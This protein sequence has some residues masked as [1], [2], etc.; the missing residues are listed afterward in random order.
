[1][2]LPVEKLV[3]LQLMLD[4]TYDGDSVGITLLGEVLTEL[5]SLAKGGPEE[6]ILREL[7]QLSNAPDFLERVRRFVSKKL[8]GKADIV[9]EP[10]EF[11]PSTPSSNEF[12]PSTPSSNLPLVK[13]QELQILLDMT[14]EGDV[15]GYQLLAEQFKEL[16]SI[17]NNGPATSVLETLSRTSEQP[18]Y[19]ERV[20]AF[21]TEFGSQS[22]AKNEEA[23]GNELETFQESDDLIDE[24]VEEE[25]NTEDLVAE[26]SPAEESVDFQ[27][28]E[29]PPPFV[30]L[31]PQDFLDSLIKGEVKPQPDTVDPEEAVVEQLLR[32]TDVDE[33]VSE[34]GRVNAD[35]V[36]HEATS[37]EENGDEGLETEEDPLEDLGDIAPE[38][39]VE[40]DLDILQEFGT[41]AEEHIGAIEQVILEAEGQYEKS[42]IDTI[43]RGIHSIKGGS[44]Y[45]NL[46]EMKKC[47]HLLEDMLH[48][49][50]DGHRPMDSRL[51]QLCLFYL[52]CQK[53]ALKRYREASASGSPVKR[54]DDSLRLLHMIRSFDKGGEIQREP[55]QIGKSTVKAA[56]PV[57]PDTSPTEAQIHQMTEVQVAVEV[58]AKSSDEVKPTANVSGEPV[59]SAVP[60]PK[61][62]EVI[63]EPS[64]PKGVFPSAAPRPIPNRSRSPQA[65]TP[66][67]TEQKR[68]AQLAKKIANEAAEASKKFVKV[69]TERLDNLIDLIGEM[70]VFSSVLVRFCKLHMSDHKDV[71]DAAHRVEKFSK[72]LQDVGISMRLDPIRGLFQKMQRLVWDTS[73]RLG[74]DIVFQMEGEDTELD[75]N[76]IDRL[77]DP[78]MHMVRN[79]LDHGIE[80]NDEREAEGKPRKGTIKLSAYHSGGNVHIK[81]QDDGRGLD[82]AKLIAKA[83]DKGIIEEGKRISNDEAFQLIFAPGFSTA[84]QVTDLSGRGVGMDVVRRNVEDLR[85]RIHIQSIVGEGAAFIIELPLTLAIIEGIQISVGVENFIIPS[86]SIVEFLRPRR[87]M[88]SSAMDSAETFFFRGKYLPLFR[89]SEV[90]SIENAIEDPERASIVVLEENGDQ[91]AFLVDTIEGEC[92]TVIKSLGEV[93]EDVKGVSGGAIMPQGNVVLILDV[94]SLVRLAQDTYSHV[95]RVRE[96]NST[97][98]P[99]IVIH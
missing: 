26:S 16:L 88:I 44:A 42:A 81:I 64:K 86:L 61:K 91:F 50:R 3:E 8:G 65:P 32:G 36:I 97:Q 83:I 55:T 15:I 22:R 52:D 69:D 41:E 37:E 98:T 62:P 70:V 92:S 17:E 60:R 9:E 11:E 54:S 53:D 96:L 47:S 72:E 25:A 46:Q 12:E 59:R 49:V 66:P 19:L 40:G 76:L 43:F 29:E 31:F 21:L 45:F 95:E 48:E 79:S 93:F 39:L 23:K 71:M 87:G 30:D 18:N 73:K 6:G 14:H 82:P 68:G 27:D 80:P 51:E 67:V 74:K 1:M 78:L 85:G 77:A 2:T 84:A 57:Q 34:E 33:S 20:R 90:Y 58:K 7:A 5:V 28:D 63:A 10:V 4:M 56:V 75:R 94:K 99:P 35:E 89:M 13:L 38:Y 24:D